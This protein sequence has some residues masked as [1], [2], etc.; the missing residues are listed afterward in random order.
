[1]EFKRKTALS[2]L[3]SRLHNL[4][5]WKKSPQEQEPDSQGPLFLIIGLGNPGREYRDTRHNVGFMVLNRLADDLGIKMSRVQNK[6]ITGSGML[7]GNRIILAKPQT[8]MNLSGGP[9]GGLVRF[10]KVPLNQMMVIHDDLDLAFGTLRIRP[11]GGS[12]GQKGIQSIINSLGNQGFP[13]MRVGI[14]RPSGSKQGASYV[15][16]GFSTLE[17]KELDFILEGASAAVRLYITDSLEM[18][19]NRYNGFQGEE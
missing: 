13:R 14:G 4:I 18:A 8:F 19:M 3:N 10:Y 5:F 7:E 16:Q 17:R 9:V 6:A 1:M 2:D 15:L 11:G 12:A